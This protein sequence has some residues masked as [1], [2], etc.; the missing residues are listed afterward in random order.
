[1]AVGLGQHDIALEL[2]DRDNS[3]DPDQVAIAE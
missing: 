2:F 3:V 1:M